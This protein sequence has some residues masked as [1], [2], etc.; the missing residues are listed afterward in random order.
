M[1]YSANQYNYAT[2]LS[3][4][5]RLT[6][7]VVTGKNLIDL[8]VEPT[9]KTS[10]KVTVEVHSPN[11]VT[12]SSA[13]PGSGWHAAYWDVSD[14][15][16]VGST[17]TAYCSAEVLASSNTA[18]IL[19][20]QTRLESGTRTW[21]KE[22]YIA[23][24]TSD[25]FTF[26]IPADIEY[27]FIEF[28]LNSNSSE[29]S[30]ELYS[31]RYSNV[32]LAKEDTLTTWEPYTGGL[33]HPV[34][35]KYFIL[36]D[37]K[38]DGSCYPVSGDAGLWGDELPNA[39]GT[40]ANPF[41][42][43]VNE[44]LTINAFRLIGSQ[45]CYPVSFTVKFYSGSTLLSTITETSNNKSE[46]IK[47]LTATLNVDSYTIEVTKVSSATSPVRLLNAYN[48]GYVSRVDT[49]RVDD[50]T[51]SEMSFLF[52]FKF[53]DSLNVSQAASRKLSTT[54]RSQDS[55]KVNQESTSAINNAI[56]V[57]DT[58]KAKYTSGNKVMN[59]I[60][61]AKDSVNVKHNDTSHIL[62]TIDV[63]KDTLKQLLREKVSHVRN[64]IDVTSDTLL[65]KYEE[66]STP[67]NIHTV[68][69]S[70]FRRVFGKVYITYT[71]PMLDSETTVIAAEAHN[72]M[73]EQI[74]DD[75]TKA[76][77]ANYFTLYENDL[78]GKYTV[79]DSES[80]VGW[81]S[82]VLSDDEGNFSVPPTLSVQFYARPI[83]NLTITFDSSR[84]NI[85]KDF[86]VTFTKDD[87]ST[88]VKEYTD[89]DDIQVIIIG[90]TDEGISDVVDITVTVKRVANPHSPAIIIDMPIS[91][92]L[93]Y[94]GYDDVSELMSVDLLEELTYE[95][96]VEALGG[97]SANE[98]TIVLDNSLKNFFFNSGS[99]VSRQLKRNRKIVPWLGAEIVPGEIEWYT[100]GTFW[101]YKWDVPANGLTTTVVGFDTI[102][103]LGNTSYSNHQ[104]QR[105]K[106]IGELIDLILE[107]AKKEL[108][109]LEW[110]I[111]ESL[112]DVVIPYA[113]FEHSSHAAALRKLS[114]CYPMHVYCDRSGRVQ[115]KSQKLKLDYYYDVWSDS[116]NVIDKN[117]SSLY[118]VL[119]NVI[120][121]EVTVPTIKNDEQLI[122]DTT[123]FVVDGAE[124]RTFNF[125]APYL[126]NLQVSVD[127]D[128]TVTYVYSVYSW[129]IAMQFTGTGTV[130]SILC[131]GSCVDTSTKTVITKQN[132]MSVKLNGAVTRNVNSEFIQ[133]TDHA[134]VIINRLFTLSEHDKYDAL[135]EYRGDIALTINDPILL[136][137]GIA[138]DNRYNI[139]R[140]ELAWN[141][142]L[143][144]SADLNT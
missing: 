142:Y 44:S 90:G 125:N 52:D 135:V 101:S 17:Y 36:S 77:N 75:I 3:S 16:E 6:S 99:L 120:S 119:P 81:I 72:S 23:S 109:F 107:D 9:W 85:V 38:L 108:T 47:K 69:K 8:S 61:V 42:V 21:Y 84:G 64:T 118:T 80:Q 106:S 59:I 53:R 116:T 32:Y 83:V 33:K 141:G 12:V 130:R 112:Y 24:G 45:Y 10:S 136:Q 56:A 63:T 74:L 14:K 20:V 126:S 121:V 67:T 68:M 122:E 43:T 86:V 131:K 13:L 93:L 30:E 51:A 29:G 46:Y 91:S 89:N 5:S 94:R 128:S 92:T 143:T 34:D 39:D 129:G 124:D 60:D 57:A 123:S 50:S 27:D 127:C 78:T 2:P 49:L 111:E 15:V 66:L 115:A 4:T 114:L 19:T 137:D 97:I 100:L 82:D 35:N 41:V 79:N 37:N 26:S 98:V 102:G 22:K 73:K 7:D 110:S 70:P 48:P 104:V 76:D 31:I 134:N 28:R 139:K 11:D 144:G 103:L 58:L 54:T 65:A 25:Y 133:T 140:H 18:C 55:L 62:N 96:E 40:L 88:I 105:N 71:D 95:D 113:W 132:A 117:Y 1:S 138:P 87:G